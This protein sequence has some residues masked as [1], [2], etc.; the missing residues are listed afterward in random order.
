M[1]VRKQPLAHIWYMKTDINSSEG[2]RRIVAISAEWTE[3]SDDYADIVN[4]LRAGAIPGFRPGKAPTGIIE[5]R[6]AEEISQAFNERVVRRLLRDA[7]AE[8]SLGPTGFVEARDI[9]FEKEEPFAFTAD[10]DVAPEIGLPDYTSFKP[11]AGTSDETARDE[12]SAYLLENCTFELPPSLVDE[13]LRTADDTPGDPSAATEEQ[14]RAAE[15]RVRLLLIL[16]RIAEE[17]GIEIDDRD[18]EERVS[19]IAESTGARRDALHTELAQ[20]NGLKRLELFLLAE[21]TMDYLLEDS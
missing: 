9:T 14:Q 15:T 6:Y 8:H 3:V 5:K 19:E 2:C 21:R 16:R 11:S 17:D 13:E 1:L 7:A 10:F 4:E 18:V 20:N 12:L